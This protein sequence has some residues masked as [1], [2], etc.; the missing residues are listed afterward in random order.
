VTGVQT[1]ALPIYGLVTGGVI[2][3]FDNEDVDAQFLGTLL[4]STDP[5][6][7]T[8]VT[9]S[10]G[11]LTNSVIIQFLADGYE[12]IWQEFLLQNADQ[13]LTLIPRLEENL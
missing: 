8:S 13:T 7:G 2:S 4:S 5:I 6:V 1:C 9:Y 12:E 10:H 3:I 11:G